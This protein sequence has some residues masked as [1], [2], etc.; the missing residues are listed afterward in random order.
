MNVDVFAGR[1]RKCPVC[2]KEFLL[3]QYNIYKTVYRGKRR[4]YCS[5]TCFRVA[6]KI[7]ESGRKHNC[8]AR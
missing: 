2:G 6:Q 8:R 1:E 4:D 7:I 5:Y 3:S